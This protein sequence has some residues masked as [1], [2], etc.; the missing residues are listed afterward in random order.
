MAATDPTHNSPDP[1]PHLLL[2][3]GCVLQILVQSLLQTL[4]VSSP[5]LRRLWQSPR[6]FLQIKVIPEQAMSWHWPTTNKHICEAR[7]GEPVGRLQVSNEARV[8]PQV[9]G[10]FTYLTL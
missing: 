2:F 9:I 5:R 7:N 1:S 4:A 6:P 8:G 10:I 3:R